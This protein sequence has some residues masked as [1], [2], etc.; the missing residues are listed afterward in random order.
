MYLE[1]IEISGFKSFGDS[2]KI[3]VPPGITAVIG[4]NGSGK[5]NVA[6]AIRWVL[7]EQSAK[8]LRGSKMED[9]IF[10]GTDK[11]KPLG[12]AEVSLLIKNENDLKISFNEIEVKRRVYR[13]GESEYF[14]NKAGCRLKDIQEIFMDTGIG[15]EGYSI[16]GQGQIDKILSSK[17]EDR[18]SLF[19]EATGIYKYKIK[20]QEANKK[21]DKEKE[22]MLRV[23]DILLEIKSH[24]VPLEKEA[25]KAKQYFKLKEDLKQVDIALFLEQ[26]NNINK[27]L[28][29][30]ENRLEIST[31]QLEDEKQNKK[32]L[33]KQEK[34]LLQQQNLFQS[35]VN[36]NVKTSIN[37]EKQNANIISEINLITEKINLIDKQIKD[38]KKEQ[39]DNLIY[40]KDLKQKLNTLN[41]DIKTK[42]TEK[43]SLE[44][45]NISLN[46][47]K[48]LVDKEKKVKAKEVSKIKDKTNKLEKDISIIEVEL[49][50]IEEI[51]INLV[52]RLT[53]HLQSLA[54]LETDLEKSNIKIK[55][56]KENKKA[57]DAKS[58][59]IKKEFVVALAEKENLSKIYKENEEQINKYN[60]DYEQ[61]NRKQNWLIS[62]K[63]NHEGF[64]N[65]VKE[66]LKISKDNFK[67]IEV[68]ANTIEVPAEYEVA[69]A[70]A[71]GGAL[72]NII[73]NTHKD[74]QNII[75]LMKQQKISRVTFLPRDTI[76]KNPID[77]KI[78]EQLVSQ[79]G[80]LSI[81]TDI[82]NCKA[83]DLAIFSFLL[84]R[85]I[86]ADNMKN[87]SNIA[88]IFDYKLRIITLD[89]EIFNVGGS[90]TGGA[91]NNIQTNIFNRSREIAE[92]KKILVEIDKKI[93]ISQQKYIS[94][95]K[96][97]QDKLS[98]LDR[99]QAEKDNIERELLQFDGIQKLEIEKNLNLQKNIA[100]LE[101]SK[102]E[103]E[104]SQI[105]LKYENKLKKLE[106]KKSENNNS[107]APTNKLE[108]ELL[109][110]EQISFKHV[111]NLSEY[112]MK[113]YT[114]EQDISNIKKEITMNKAQIE[115]IN[116]KMDFLKNKLNILSLEKA[117]YEKEIISK[118]K[119]K[120]IIKSNLKE[121]EQNRILLET[122]RKNFLKM[123]T[124]FKKSSQ[125]ISDTISNLEKEIIRQEIQIENL[126]KEIKN[127]NKYI[128]EEYN[129]DPNE[130]II[131]NQLSNI[132]LKKI[133][134]KK[135]QNTFKSQMKTIG[136]INTNAINEFHETSN[137][138]NFLSAQKEDILK[139]QN[140]LEKLIEKLTMEMNIIF[141]KEFKNIAN[142]FETIFKELFGGG[143]AKLKL[144][145][146]KNILESG[147]EIIIQP[148]GKKLQNLSLLSGGERT[149]TAI[150]LL[151]SILKLKPSPFCILDEIEAALDEANVL[152]FIKYLKSL[153]N[154]TQFIVITH[155]KGTM[156]NANTLYGITQQ[157]K[158][159]STLLSIKLSDAKNYVT[160]RK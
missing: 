20:K 60:N 71:L 152:R 10:A 16:I 110:L 67:G 59:T 2:V 116:S 48:N 5:S 119:E 65:S 84:G 63:E 66:V 9:I 50:S 93:K 88:R 37:L 138:Y 17:P 41:I 135:Q 139:A 132:D 80:F 123:E 133:D 29:Q 125:N 86:I 81:A 64:Y 79:P 24:L 150:A 151:F 99:I 31:L 98:V 39:E 121:I 149:L 34:D 127:L 30:L 96:K 87:A 44:A 53:K 35:N 49:K 73:T 126:N 101:V 113:L 62:L 61:L 42:N 14:I 46:K 95:S 19:E 104:L 158:G 148:P 155:R 141:I 102:L 145:D 4:P 100:N 108:N 69:I 58:V 3:L 32:L 57:L 107:I 21:L 36:D 85:I 13:S 105:K 157:E 18:R 154:N 92:N 137:R 43:E 134:L 140:T 106:H 142:N 117:N 124:S 144:T 76:K 38:N 129:L 160:E 115:Q 103:K 54:E 28:E 22:N 12:Y 74:A 146:E 27:T 147:I 136:T 159:V 11:R 23:D 114:I 56:L 111:E 33:I 75:T 40:I 91:Q 143:V 156:E 47:Q 55:Y 122:E 1:K 70:T 112:S 131:K 52:N 45:I 94:I 26:T 153:S 130:H 82:I 68:V 128:L 77:P 51:K 97:F 7:G 78:K 89:G 90:L 15:K 83:E 118:T 72:Q 120:E 109:E 25:E 8:T 6:D